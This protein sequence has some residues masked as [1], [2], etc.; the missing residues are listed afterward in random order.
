MW[1]SDHNEILPTSRQ[2]HCRE[3]CK[4]LLWSVQYILNQ[5][6]GN[7]GRISNSIEISLEAAGAWA[8]YDGI[9]IRTD[10]WPNRRR[11]ET[12]SMEKKD[13]RNTWPD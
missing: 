11:H 2:L 12:K 3:V 13:Y 8:S 10:I 5:S 1:S 7:F 9:K 6:T 4:I